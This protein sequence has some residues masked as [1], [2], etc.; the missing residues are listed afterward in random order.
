MSRHA[1]ELTYR[2]GTTY[3]GAVADDYRKRIGSRIRRARQRA[4]LKPRE[5]AQRLDIDQRQLS[6]WENGHVAPSPRYMRR[7]EQEL[8]VPAES[9]L[10]SD[11]EEDEPEPQAA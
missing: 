3:V 2:V 8:N 1:M 4:G 7:L 10:R 9:F 11:D 5:L 6:R